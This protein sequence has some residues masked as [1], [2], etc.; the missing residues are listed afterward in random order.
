[1]ARSVKYSSMP[2][3]GEVAPNGLQRKQSVLPALVLPQRNTVLCCAR[4][5]GACLCAHVILSS[6][7]S[8]ADVDMALQICDDNLKRRAKSCRSKTFLPGTTRG[9]ETTAR[10]RVCS[11]CN[12]QR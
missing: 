11:A 2:R 12:W 1:M 10:A 9:E 3:D 4:K 5:A 8:L 7:V 6:D